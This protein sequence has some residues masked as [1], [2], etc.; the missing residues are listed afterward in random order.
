MSTDRAARKA[1]ELQ[2]L[3]AE[4]TIVAETTADPNRRRVL[5]AVALEY[6]RLAEFV[7]SRPSKSSS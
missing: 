6:K 1:D 4:A 7:R 3:A 2:K 5:R